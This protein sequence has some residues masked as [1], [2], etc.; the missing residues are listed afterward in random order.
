MASNRPA[1]L[2]LPSEVLDMVCDELGKKQDFG[3]LF[4]CAISSKQLAQPALSLLYRYSPSVNNCRLQSDDVARVYNHSNTEGADAEFSKPQTFQARKEQQIR[5][6]SKYAL[7]WKSLIRSSIGKTAYPYAQYICSLDLR[8]FTYLL[9]DTLFRDYGMEEFF[10]D[11]MSQFLKAQETPIKKRTRKGNAVGMRIDIPVVL[12]LVGESIT[13]YL[14][15]VA[16]EKNARVALDDIAPGDI[17]SSVLPRWIGRLSQLKSMTLWDGV[18]LNEDAAIAINNHC[19]KFND[20]TFFRCS[21]EDADPDIAAFFGA[22]KPNTLESLTALSAEG[23][24]PETLLALNN[25]ANSLKVLKI[26]GLTYI[27]L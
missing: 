3:T 27:A 26:D 21:R 5:A 22:L 19:P 6:M 2:S 23:I 24:G 7:L 12:D 11:D 20:V 8:N 25:H 15:V 1:V 17:S 13:S 10:A 4:N 14:S 9:E 18:V 16:T